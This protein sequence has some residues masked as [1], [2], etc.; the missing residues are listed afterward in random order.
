MKIILFPLL[1]AV[2][3]A[4]PKA[5]KKKKVSKAASCT[6]DPSKTYVYG[7]NRECFSD[8]LGPREY[9][10]VVP[11]GVAKLE[12][13]LAGGSGGGGGAGTGGPCSANS[14]NFATGGSGGDGSA[15]QVIGPFELAV[16][17]GEFLEIDVGCGGEGGTSGYWQGYG[18]GGWGGDG[19]NGDGLIDGS[20]ANVGTDA[21][22]SGGGGGGGGVTFVK[23]NGQYAVLDSNA[24][25]PVESMAFGG[26]GGGGGAGGSECPGGD[27]FTLPSGDDGELGGSGGIFPN[28]NSGG[29]GGLGLMQGPVNNGSVQGGLGVAGEPGQVIP[30]AKKAQDGDDGFV[31]IRLCMYD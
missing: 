12:L 6:I 3:A 16:S 28:G 13:T 2:A 18:I 14:E 19:V 1:V 31:Q 24:V 27:T 29:Q 10:F 11:P 5:Q 9:E 7:C 4:K 30:K 25:P 15:G 22:G 23:V 26:N 20:D 8:H 21:A 17:E